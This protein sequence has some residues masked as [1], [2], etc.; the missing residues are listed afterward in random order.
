MVLI[1]WPPSLPH[2]NSIEN[3]WGM[4]KKPIYCRALCP[5]AV[6]EMQHAIKEEW[7][8]IDDSEIIAIVNALPERVRAVTAASGGSTRY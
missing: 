8:D 3:V 1:D 6:L 4:L 7:A 2:L 5:A